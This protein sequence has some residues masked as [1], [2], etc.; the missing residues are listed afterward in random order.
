[1]TLE[2]SYTQIAPSYDET[3]YMSPKAQFTFQC[4]AALLRRAILDHATRRQRLLDAACGTGQFTLAV[5]DLFE[6][7]IGVDLTLDMLRQAQ[8]KVGRSGSAT[9]ALVNGSVEHLPLAPASVDVVLTTRFMHLFPREHHRRLLDILM[10]PLRP[11]GV[12]IV[13]HDTPWLEWMSWLSETFRGRR[14]QAWSTY[15]HAEMP[16]GV[17]RAARMGVSMPGLPTLSLRWPAA[18]LRLA[19]SSVSAPMNRLS[20]FTIIVYRKLRE[21]IRR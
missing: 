2:K 3:R 19:R 10:V 5:G 11:G 16:D 13:E 7:V 15:H 20:S 4:E 18:A 21:P 12:L 6:T 17:Q 9:T 1:L 8:T 14:K